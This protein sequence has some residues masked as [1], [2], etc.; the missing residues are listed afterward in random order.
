MKRRLQVEQLEARDTPAT[1]TVNTMNDTD[2]ANLGDG[3]ALDAAGKTSLRAAVQEAD[4]LAKKFDY[5]HTI[6]I[7]PVAPIP[8]ITLGSTL[9]VTTATL[10]INGRPAPGTLMITR[11]SA[12]PAFPLLRVGQFGHCTVTDLTFAQGANPNG[13]GGGLI[14]EGTLVLQRCKV[15]H[16]SA[17]AGGGIFN[18]LHLTVVDSQITFN[19]AAGSGGGIYCDGNAN[20]TAVL[21]NTLVQNNSAGAGG[22]IA[23]DLRARLTLESCTVKANTATGSGGGVWGL[24]AVLEVRGGSIEGNSAGQD[25]GGVYSAAAGTCNLTQTLVKDNTATAWGGGIH[26]IGGTAGVTNCAFA[27]N[28]ATGGGPKISWEAFANVS[29]VVVVDP[30]CTGV[31][32]GDVAKK[33]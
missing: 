33:M 22:G 8:S 24:T 6:N 28:A 21:R 3:Q 18:R 2:D 20:C 26:V 29:A 16:C 7:D 11:N 15:D 10:T 14:N 17:M 27:G 5:Y 19:T 9:E 25:G 23:V 1:F 13:S 31:A 12:G 30:T 4:E 32:Q